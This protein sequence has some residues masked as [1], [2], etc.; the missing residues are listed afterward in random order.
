VKYLYFT[1]K[2]LYDA[3]LVYRFWQN[4]I[5]SDVPQPVLVHKI[6]L[7]VLISSSMNPMTRKPILRR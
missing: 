1:D 3:G 2:P 6:I 4:E 7:N 5:V